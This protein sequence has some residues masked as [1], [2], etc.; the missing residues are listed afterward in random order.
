MMTKKQLQWLDLPF[1]EEV[2]EPVQTVMWV[3][4]FENG[5]RVI[6]S[7]NHRLHVLDLG[8]CPPLDVEPIESYA[9]GRE[10]V[11][12]AVKQGHPDLDWI[13]R[14]SDPIPQ[15]RRLLVGD[16]GW[17]AHV[18]ADALREAVAGLQYPVPEGVVIQGRKDKKAFEAMRSVFMDSENGALRLRSHVFAKNPYFFEGFATD[19]VALVKTSRPIDLEPYIDPALQNHRHW[20]MRSRFLEDAIAPMGPV[21][22]IRGR[23]PRA[24]ISLE[25]GPYRVVIAMLRI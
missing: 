18:R 8:D 21:I 6:T 9:L 16:T 13:P 2:P 12:R 4:R 5:H 7:D 25:S 15:W 19:H 22:T 11:R 24:N 20:A 1:N 3:E 17:K 23:S 10:T 14:L